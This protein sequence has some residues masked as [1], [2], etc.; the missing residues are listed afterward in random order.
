VFAIWCAAEA[1]CSAPAVIWMAI[2]AVS[3]AE[4]L[5]ADARRRSSSIILPVARLSRPISSSAADVASR[6]PKSPAA[7]ASAAAASAAA[8]FS[9]RRDMNVLARAREPSSASSSPL[10]IPRSHDRAIPSSAST[11]SSL[12]WATTRQTPPLSTRTAARWRS[13]P[14]S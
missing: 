1:M 12:V 5:I 13:V 11:R 6:V 8:G 14:A 4:P 7:T 3:C 9:M 10:P 2:D